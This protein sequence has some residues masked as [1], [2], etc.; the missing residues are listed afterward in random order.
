MYS[1]WFWSNT[2]QRKAKKKKRF[3]SEHIVVPIH[4]LDQEEKMLP[5]PWLDGRNANFEYISEP[6]SLPFHQLFMLPHEKSVNI[7]KA[8]QDW[9]ECIWNLIP[10][11]I[12]GNP[13]NWKPKRE[14][15][16]AGFIFYR[17]P[18]PWMASTWKSLLYL[19][20]LLKNETPRRLPSIRPTQTWYRGCKTTHS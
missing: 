3:M 1:E 12:H 10:K 5:R 14:V 17:A 8:R 4:R 11:S 6:T 16:P 20:G 15:G 7:I 18:N 9:T 13:I 19:V 2:K